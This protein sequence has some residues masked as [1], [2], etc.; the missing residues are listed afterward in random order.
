MKWDS[1]GQFDLT[2]RVAAYTTL[3]VYQ[4]KYDDIQRVVA[5]DPDGVGPIPQTTNTVNAAKA[6]IEG[7]ELTAGMSFGTWLEISGYWGYVDAVHDEFDND[8]TASNPVFNPSPTNPVQCGST[9][10]TA[11]GPTVCKDVGF[12]ISKDTA[13]VVASLSPFD[14]P[15]IGRIT[16]TGTYSYRSSFYGLNTL[17]ILE[18]FSKVPSQYNVN[19]TLDWSDMFGSKLSAQAW[20]RN[21]TDEQNVIANLSLGRSL[22]L[23]DYVYSDPRM[24]GLTLTYRFGE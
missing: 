14:S 15:E 20:V 24:Y 19:A 17:P 6:T 18:E 3:A 8:F 23:A 21:A 11:P 1:K 9:V 7:F 12:G 2:D 22:G 10:V 5:L 4:T 13:G 16:L